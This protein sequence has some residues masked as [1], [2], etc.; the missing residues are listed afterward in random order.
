MFNHFEK[1]LNCHKI[2]TQSYFNLNQGEKMKIVK[3][4]YFDE[5][6]CLADKCQNTCCANWDI[7][8]DSKSLSKYSNTSGLEKIDNYCIK[9]NNDYI[10]KSK[11]NK[12]VFLDDDNLCKLI[13]KYGNK[14]L[15]E[16]CT[17]FPR[18]YINLKTY[19]FVGLGLD[20]EKVASIVLNLKENISF[21]LT[22]TNRKFDKNEDTIFEKF[23]D[24]NNLLVNSNSFN[25]FVF[26]VLNLFDLANTHCN[27]N[28]LLDRNFLSLT[29]NLDKINNIKFEWQNENAKSIFKYA[30]D[31]I[32]TNI[33]LSDTQL[34]NLFICFLYKHYFDSRIKNKEKEMILYAIFM[35]LCCNSLLSLDKSNI[36]QNIS[37]LVRQIEDDYQNFLQIFNLLK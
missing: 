29:L 3:P 25:E 10:F 28:I 20:C 34:K 1:L 32:C 7:L 33:Y 13:K 17:E 35:T 15:C 21:N 31:N 2:N 11:N 14:Y 9:K 4:N 36:S 30:I 6:Y 18:F 12:C 37:Y 24:I 16:V 19:S 23:K 26:E 27:T 22:K 5:F 8:L